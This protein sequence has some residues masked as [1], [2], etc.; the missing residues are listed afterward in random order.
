MTPFFPQTL[1]TGIW[2]LL[3]AV[4]VVGLVGSLILAISYWGARERK[5]RD[6]LRRRLKR[7]TIV[8]LGI[9][10]ALLLIDPFAS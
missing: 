2:L 9:V 8:W 5:H 6:V 7:F 1:D 4:V 10:A 3:P